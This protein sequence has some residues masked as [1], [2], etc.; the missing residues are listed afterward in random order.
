MQ[1]NA[2]N[3]SPFQSPNMAPAYAA[4]AHG[5]SPYKPRMYLYSFIS[6]FEIPCE[7]AFFLMVIN[8]K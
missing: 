7:I 3:Q 4:S 1:Q 8:D 5:M 6:L 2:R